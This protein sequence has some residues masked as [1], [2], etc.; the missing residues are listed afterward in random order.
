MVRVNPLTPEERAILDL[1]KRTWKYP[2]SK[3]RAVRRELGIPA[4][5]YYMRVNALIEDP[6]A[7]RE[8]PELTRRLREQRD[9][10]G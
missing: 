2:G 9:R 3:E 7:I 1:E 8:E 5:Q 6:R 10:L 4:T